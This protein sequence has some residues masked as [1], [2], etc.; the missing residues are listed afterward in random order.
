MTSTEAVHLSGRERMLGQNEIIVSKTNL[1]GH[2]TY[3]ND[4]FCEIADY[5]NNDVFGKPHNIVRNPK[6][7]RCV[8]KLLWDYISAGKE[9]F[10]YVVN[11]GK[12]GDHYWVLAHVTPSF[13][14]SGSMIGYHSNRRSPSRKAIQTMEG[15]Y[16]QLLTEERKH[17]DRR[18][19]MMESYKL[20]QKI[21]DEKGVSYDEFILSL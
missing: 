7:P 3:A 21:L 5:T 18:E 8:F 20:L 12:L 6:M 2:L 1:K 15:L 9:I 10:A 19:G 11:R 14:E 17:G 4:I 13:D 16:D